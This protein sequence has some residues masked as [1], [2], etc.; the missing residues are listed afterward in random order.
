ME[1]HRLKVPEDSIEAFDVLLES[2]YINVVPVL[3]MLDIVLP[4]R[5]L[6]P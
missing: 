3:E 1:K 4:N 5:R 6:L 2:M